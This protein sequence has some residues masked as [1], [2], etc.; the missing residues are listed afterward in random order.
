MADTLT[1]ELP[2]IKSMFDVMPGTMVHNMSSI[3]IT[4]TPFARSFLEI[5]SSD[6]NLITAMITTDQDHDCFNAGNIIGY[7]AD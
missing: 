6:I 4:E 3:F 5:K 2:H 1:T 7:F